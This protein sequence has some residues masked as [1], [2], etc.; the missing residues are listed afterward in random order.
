METDE[1]AVALAVAKVTAAEDR[2]DALQT[3]ADAFR[4]R[5]EEHSRVL[6]AARL[7][8]ANVLE[9]EAR[10]DAAMETAET[11]R[12]QLLEVEG[13]E[14]D[15]L[16]VALAVA[17]VTAAEDRAAALRTEA[18]AFRARYAAHHNRS[19]IAAGY[20]IPKD[21]WDMMN[22]FGKHQHYMAK[23]EGELALAEWLKLVDPLAYVVRWIIAHLHAILSLL[24]R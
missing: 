18:N 2:A 1:L 12:A 6:S 21:L 11:L 14:T 7:S 4:A 19:A 3:E 8:H 5:V 16:A 10:A 13:M 9:K 24:S 17:K 23:E 20:G 15:E 22:G